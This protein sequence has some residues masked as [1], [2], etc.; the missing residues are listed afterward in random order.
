M[1]KF[2]CILITLLVGLAVFAGCT[3][4]EEEPT[5]APEDVDIVVIAA[6]D[7]RF[8]TLVT[9][10]QNAELVETLQGQGPFTVFAPTDEAFD[11]LTEVDIES[12]SPSELANVLQYHVVSG[13]IMSDELEGM[14]SVTTL[15]GEDLMVTVDEDSGDISV[16]NATVIEADIEGSNGVIHVID[17]V[18][19][20]PSD[21][22]TPPTDNVT[23]TEDIVDIAAGDERFATLVGALQVTNLADSLKGEGPFTVFAPT[24]EAFT[25]VDI[26]SMD[27]S[28]LANILEYH[29]V[30][31]KVMSDEL[32]GMTSVTTLSGENL[33]VTVDEASGDI[34]VDNATVIE[35]DIEASN[36][37]IH[38]IDGVLLPPTDNVTP[39]T[40]NM[41]PPNDNLTPII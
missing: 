29:V 8:D 2:A 38:V 41:T 34:S 27:P 9:A 22:M 3:T 28:E 19:L 23:P 10:L 25:A 24:D 18:L 21:N 33:T 11:D 4:D 6:G 16:D 37:V 13:K 31:G 17:A 35:P 39:P 36:G 5:P 7:E 12:L 26:E 20:P 14:T 1:K 32:A 30:P 15:S 40:D